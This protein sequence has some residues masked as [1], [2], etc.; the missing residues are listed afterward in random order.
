MNP[1]E[2]S[3]VSRFET[4]LS[5]ATPPSVTEAAYDFLEIDRAAFRARVN[6]I[7]RTRPARRVPL[8]TLAL[9][10]VENNNFVGTPTR[11]RL[12]RQN[13]V[14][15]LWSFERHMPHNA[16]VAAR[17]QLFNG[18]ETGDD[19]NDDEVEKDLK[20]VLRKYVFAAAQMTDAEWECAICKENGMNDVVWHPSNCHTFHSQCLTRW[21]VYDTRC[22]L[23]RSC[24]TPL[25]MKEVSN[26]G[27]GELM[28]L[29]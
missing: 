2:N 1:S 28:Q 27:E 3:A 23:C 10:E 25:L 24:T 16:N 21:M 14:I 15:F 4:L 13:A 11:P 17:L 22:P 12:Q 6:E 9:P 19:G 7:V 18:V 26:E 29:D 5:A 20:V 8:V